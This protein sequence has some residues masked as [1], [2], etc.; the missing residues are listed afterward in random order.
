[1]REVIFSACASW[2]WVYILGFRN[3]K[4]KPLN[5][6]KCMGGWICLA[7]SIGHY[8]WFEIPFMICIAM[9][10]TIILTQIMNR[11]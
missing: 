8:Q 2:V 3:F 6:E 7:L 4:Y 1:M 5:C 11:I 10:A 9:V